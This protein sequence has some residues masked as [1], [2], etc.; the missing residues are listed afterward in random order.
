MMRILRWIGW[1]L[2]ALVV[3]VLGAHVV[4]SVKWARHAN[5]R[6]AVP[7]IAFGN[8]RASAKH[9][10]YLVRVAAACTECHGD[11]LAGGV[12]VEDFVPGHIYG[13]NITQAALKDWTDAEIAAT[14]H[15]GV[16]RTGRPL[17]IMPSLNFQF[18]CLQDV[19]D[20]VAFLRHLPPVNK[21]NRVTRVGRII[22]VLWALGQVSDVF[23]AETVDHVRTF[24]ARVPEGPT[25]AYGR[26]LY[27]SHCAGCHREDGRGGKVTSGPPDWPPAANLTQDGAGGWKQA[28][29]I[30]AF[31][32]GVN[33][34]GSAIRPPMGDAIRRTG[35]LIKE[36]DLKALWSYLHT[37]KGKDVGF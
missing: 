21:A 20:M 15:H 9:G 18:L 12:V 29:F 8:V 33:A 37:L 35:K 16:D 13:P 22:K 25:V 6:I 5:A 3:L 4:A 26:Y 36:H 24:T 7:P 23:P 17:L 30:R 14:I 10:E 32:T 2:G 34:S 28:E 11:D 1:G 19:A 27:T 31:R